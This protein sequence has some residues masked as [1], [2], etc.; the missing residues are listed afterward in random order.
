LTELEGRS[1][2]QQ[3]LTKPRYRHFSG[4]ETIISARKGRNKNYQATGGKPV[5]IF[6]L[7]HKNPN[8]QV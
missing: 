6:G 7:E 5:E 2:G 4:R 1:H 8:F 3:R